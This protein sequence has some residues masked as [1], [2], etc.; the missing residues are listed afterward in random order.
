M[1]MTN[2]ERVVWAAAYIAERRR[3][4]GLRRDHDGLIEMAEVARLEEKSFRS[5]LVV[6]A[7]EVER[8]RGF[9]PDLDGPLNADSDAVLLL[10]SM[11]WGHGE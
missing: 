2:G 5:A 3:V 9:V 6:A 10:R 4:Q 7:A 11:L 1:V 8:L